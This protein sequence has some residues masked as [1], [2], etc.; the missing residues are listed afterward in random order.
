MT[1]EFLKDNPLPDKGHISGIAS[2]DIE[3]SGITFNTDNLFDGA[4]PKNKFNPQ[5]KQLKDIEYLD[6]IADMYK[7]MVDFDSNAVVLQNDDF[8]LLKEDAYNHN[9]LGSDVFE[10]NKDLQFYMEESFDLKDRYLGICMIQKNKGSDMFLLVYDS[11]NNSVVGDFTKSRFYS[12][13][14]LNSFK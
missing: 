11:K 4:G 14:V 8:S 1:D 3:N 9:F 2:F 12:Q 10:T 13:N 7:I 5:K 6:F